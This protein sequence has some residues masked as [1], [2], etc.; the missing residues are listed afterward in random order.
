MFLL[1]LQ[2]TSSKPV[3]TSCHINKHEKYN[4]LAPELYDPVKLFDKKLYICETCHKHLNK[5]KIPCEAVCNKM[6]VDPITN[7]LK[8]FKKWEKVLKI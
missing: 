4:M 6:V 3:S 7:D 1:H 2:N 8:D 5:K